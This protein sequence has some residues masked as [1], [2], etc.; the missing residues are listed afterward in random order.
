MY[1]FLVVTE[2][3]NTGYSAYIP[4]L[5]GCIATGRTHDIV[6]KNIREAID[7]HI[8][9]MLEDG[10]AIPKNVTIADYVSVA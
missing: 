10:L 4:D 9:G 3:T 8:Q 5:P 7:F 6:A 1:R 2:K